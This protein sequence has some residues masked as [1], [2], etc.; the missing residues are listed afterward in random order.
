MIDTKYGLKYSMPHSV[1]HI[2]D[3]SAYTG[4]LPVV[5]ADDPSMYATLVVTGAPMGVDNKVVTITRSDVANTAFG[6]GA[7]TKADRKKYGQSI[8]YPLDLISQGAPVKFMR[9][10]PDDAK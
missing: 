7:I 6:L 2:V 3:N 10:T 9:V 8:D 1:V 5:V 4:P